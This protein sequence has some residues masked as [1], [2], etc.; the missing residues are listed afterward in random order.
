MSI[1]Y[2]LNDLAEKIEEETGG[3]FT[4]H[5]FFKIL[6]KFYKKLTKKDK[7]DL[8]KYI[9]FSSINVTINNP[10]ISLYYLFKYF[11]N[12]LSIKIYSPSLIIYEIAEA[13][14]NIYQKSTLEFFVSNGFEASGKITDEDLIK[15]FDKELKIDKLSTSIFYDMVNFSEDKE[16][17]IED[18]I[19]AIDS[20]R[21]DDFNLDFNEKEKNIL[22]LY[23]IMEKYSIELNKILKEIKNNFVGVDELKSQIL[24]KIEM[25][26]LKKEEIIG[27]K[28]LDE[29]LSLLSEDNNIN[30]K[31]FKNLYSESKSKLNVENLELNINKK[32]WINK[33]IDIL[34]SVCKK[35]QDIFNSIASE[36]N[37]IELNKLKEKLKKDFPKLNSNNINNII[38]SFDVNNNGIIEYYQYENCINQIL[39]P[40]NNKNN[41]WKCGIRS[42]NYYVLPIK[43][44][45]TILSNYNTKINDFIS[46]YNDKKGRNKIINEKKNSEYSSNKS[47]SIKKS[48]TIQK[49][50]NY[51][52]EYY[53]KLS[54]EK[55]NFTNNFFTCIDLLNFLVHQ[56]NFS[57]DYSYEIIKY[58]DND[59]D[60]YISILDIIKFLLHK[61]KYKSVKLVLK[62]LYIKIYQ[63][64]NCSSCDEFFKNSNFKN[65]EIINKQKLYKFLQ[66]LNIEFPL[67]NK[68]IEE[69]KFNYHPP[70]VY[71]YLYDAIDGA[72][73]YIKNNIPNNDNKEQKG[74]NYNYNQFQE[75]IKYYENY[76]NSTDTNNSSSSSKLH[77]IL[78]KCDDIMD[79][80]NYTKNFSEPLKLNDLF[81][82]TLFQLLKT[83]SK[84]GTQLINKNDLLIFFDSFSN[85]NLIN[86]KK[87]K[88]I[89]NLIEIGAPIN[90]AFENLPFRKSGIIPSAELI[91][92]LYHFY[93]GAFNKNDLNLI[94][95]YLDEQKNGLIEYKHLQIFLNQN[96]R[97]FSPSLELQVVACNIFKKY[98]NCNDFFDKIKMDKI[99]KETHLTLLKNMCSN[100]INVSNLFLYLSN[101]SKYYHLEKFEN[102]IFGYLELAEHEGE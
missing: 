2:P 8:L 40:K 35:P 34:S 23:N 1:E 76:L 49:T 11:S 37:S 55:F 27:E 18:I 29:I 54:F 38:T 93:N 7:K 24:K 92:H 83:I 80:S 51:N 85:K 72:K 30:I 60:G 97:I 26:N 84:N 44:N 56:E 53:L 62:Y 74:I 32:F 96:Y 19:L 75:E 65:N 77:K 78:K 13:F 101:Y 102:L 71:Q 100:E 81:S 17:N 22:Y 91:N 88:N 87:H 73:K 94:V 10:F 6:E 14:K 89:P 48:I 90:F 79:Y 52:E 69:L 31:E 28:V 70:L 15:L 61:L 21:D 57:F 58:L 25:K 50:E 39:K 16:V 41:I 82:L 99:D 12:S 98:K 3:K 43:G 9:P 64:S 33:Y 59:N 46:N 66:D 20:Y 45:Y 4:F 42:T 5:Q 47:L 36:E 68:L 67:T 95:N 86:E 63:E